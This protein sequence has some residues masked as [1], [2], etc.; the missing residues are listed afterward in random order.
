MLRCHG[1]GQ[2][3]L[4]VDFAVTVALHSGAQHADV[5]RQRFRVFPRLF[6]WALRQRVK[7][8]GVPG[9]GRS[10][11]SGVS[12]ALWPQDAPP[13]VRGALVCAERTRRVPSLPEEIPPQGSGTFK[14]LL[15]LY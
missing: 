12:F 3:L 14:S 5:Q 9:A 13:R 10:G 7:L 15:Q 8:R 2:G 11:R 1:G 6:A 4:W